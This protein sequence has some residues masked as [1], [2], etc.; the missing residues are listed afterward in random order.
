MAELRQLDVGYGYTADGGQTFPF[1]GK[2]V[3]L[4]P[5][6][7][8]VLAAFPD[9]RLL[10]NVKSHDRSEGEKLAAVLNGLAASRRS[11]I[12]IYGGDEPIEVIKATRTGYQ[13]HFAREHQELPAPLHRLWL[14]RRGSGSLN[15]RAGTGADQC[16]AVALGLARSIPGP[17]ESR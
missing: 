7:S 11:L 3:G 5:S 13:D 10:I 1:R 8:G 2:G 6:L 9:Q 14:D 17:H 16:R 15:A 4:M 12:M